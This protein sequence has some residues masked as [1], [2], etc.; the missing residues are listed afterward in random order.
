VTARYEAEIKLAERG[1][2][3]L[4][5]RIALKRMP[6]DALPIGDVFNLLKA[7]GERLEI[8]ALQEKGEKV[9]KRRIKKATRSLISAID[10]LTEWPEEPRLRVAAE[11]VTTLRSLELDTVAENL[12]VALQQADAHAGDVAKE[13]VEEPAEETPPVDVLARIRQIIESGEWIPELEE[14][15]RT[16]RDQTVEDPDDDLLNLLN[17]GV[18]FNALAGRKHLLLEER[19]RLAEAEPLPEEFAAAFAKLPETVVGSELSSLG[20]HLVL[21]DVIAAGLVPERS[22][23]EMTVAATLVA[24]Q[25]LD[26]T[27][28]KPDIDSLGSWAKT[29]PL[30]LDVQSDDIAPVFKW[31]PPD[32]EGSIER[33]H[34]QRW[35]VQSLM[36]QFLPVRWTPQPHEERPPYS[37]AKARERLEELRDLAWLMVDEI[38]PV[39]FVSEAFRYGDDTP[40]AVDLEIVRDVIA[41]WKEQSLVSA[42]EDFGRAYLEDEWK[43][44]IPEDEVDEPSELPPSPK[45]ADGEPLVLCTVAFDVTEG[46]HDEIVEQL[47]AAEGFRKERGGGANCWAWLGP[48]K[49]S[50]KVHA[51]L[52]LEEELFT[53]QTQSLAWASKANSRLV[54]ELGDRIVLKDIRTQEATAEMLAELGIDVGEEESEAPSEDQKQVV[55][56][57]LENHYRKWLYE[58]LP[59]LDDAP[60]RDAVTDPVARAEVIKLLIE[61]E[62]RTRASSWPMNEFDFDFL[63][64]E[65]GLSRDE[66]S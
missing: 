23:P 46:A 58:P 57:V 16:L 62:E 22:S 7:V 54:E 60:P 40:G 49:R 51:D 3:V 65:L 14:H 37:A 21:A 50:G 15:L 6:A 12:L 11:L 26:E 32:L 55:H 13:T 24:M 39:R 8:D 25:R 42:V 43:H 5:E 41:L 29:M 48:S 47:D 56:Q 30:K 17:G 38:E 63:W 20:L 28:K 9:S 2:H 45:T 52:T 36:Y 34:E 18:V 53:V 1:Y 4:M 44:E 64:E 35:K 66:A 33:R 19:R 10:R 27:G 61:A 31:E 59:A